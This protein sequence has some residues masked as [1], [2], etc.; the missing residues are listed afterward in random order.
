MIAALF[1]RAA[2]PSLPPMPPSTFGAAALAVAMREIG[3]GESVAN[4]IGP[5]L[6]R[7]R[8]GGPGGAWC[9]A[10]MSYC[11]ET[12]AQEIGAPLPL[13]RSHRA[14]RLY[15]RAIAA[16]SRAIEPMPGDLA[17]W[18]RGVAGARTGHIGI[19]SRGLVDGLWHAIEGNRGG[20][21]SRVREYPHELGEAMFIGFARLP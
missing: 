20:F 6:D 19:V 14:K 1:R 10:L 12:G 13:T 9:A 16:G 18:H 3:K 7:Y 15:D 2:P 4:N 5:D 8:C 11:L 21:P 17:C